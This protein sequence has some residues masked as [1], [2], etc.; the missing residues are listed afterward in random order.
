MLLDDLV[1][2]IETLK[3]RI[4]THGATLRENETRTRM[5]LIDPLLQALGWDTADPLLVMPEYA[6]SGSRA[7]YALLKLDGKPSALVEAKKLGESLAS[8][9]L[10]M[11]SYANMSGVSYAGL[12]D[13]DN[14]E[15]Y[16][17]FQKR[18][19]DDKRVIQASIADTPVSQ[20]A[21]MLSFLRHT[22]LA[23]GHTSLASG[24][25]VEAYAP[26]LVEETSNGVAPAASRDDIDPQRIVSAVADYFELPVDDLVARNRK[27]SV[28]LLRQVVMYLLTYELKLPPTHVGRLLGGRDHSTVI[29][30]AKKVNSDINDN[31]GL[32]GHV[33][34]IMELAGLG[35]GTD[36]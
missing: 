11:V 25:T 12:T 14:W 24:Q 31:T 36:P 32:L 27:R 5:A 13:G 28:S 21:M 10:Q 17:V 19:L 9:R 20:C 4:D 2:V 26:F 30:G 18:P 35:T 1:G 33:L 8:H 7:D 6:L 22:S 29:Y 3:G 23:S 16:D 34:A 15:V